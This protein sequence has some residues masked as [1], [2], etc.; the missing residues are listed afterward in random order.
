MGGHDAGKVGCA[1][2]GCHK[3]DDATLTGS[4]Y[5]LFERGGRAVSA[6][7]FLLVFHFELVEDLKGPLHHS[8]IA[9]RSHYYSDFHFVISLCYKFLCKST[10]AR[11]SLRPGASL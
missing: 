8:E 6:E 11:T 1:S 9:G 4:L 2:G 7:Y 5:P 10:D 3:C